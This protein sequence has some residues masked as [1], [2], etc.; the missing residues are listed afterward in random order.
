[1][2]RKRTG[3]LE[4][5]RILD[6]TRATA[7]PFASMML[8]DLGAEVIKI[9]TPPGSGGLDSRSKLDTDY[10][11]GDDDL[12]FIAFNRNKKSVVL[13]LR[14]NEGKSVFYDLTKISDVVI[15]NFRP[16]VL[17]R[18]KLDFD[19]LK[20]FNPRIISCSNSGFG[21][22]GPRMMNPAFDIIILG[23]SGLLEAFNCQEEDGRLSPFPLPLADHL[24]GMWMAF[25][26]A[27][28][29]ANVS[30]TGEGQRID[31]AMLDGTISLM[32]AL[33][34]YILNFGLRRRTGLMHLYGTFKTANGNIIIAAQREKFFINLCKAI[35]KEDILTDEKYN[36]ISKRMSNHK[37]LRALIEESLATKGREEWIEILHKADVPCGPVLSIE[38]ALKDPQLEARNM[39]VTLTKGDTK[40]RVLG[41]P[42]KNSII[43]DQQYNYPPEYGEHTEVVLSETLGYTKEKINELK[44]LNAIT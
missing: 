8:A 9:E 13:D 2:E 25:S 29:L 41:N 33:S 38:E 34:S 24:G 36:T 39:I 42:V 6:V 21:Y 43:E 14:K 40:V 30:R 28:A 7:G 22:S 23:L 10:Q 11:I 15:D 35:Q 18:L 17:E 44:S 16:G 31:V 27:A 20:K 5:I 3:P 4:G 26:V 1:M 12:H 37:Q 32:G 19:T